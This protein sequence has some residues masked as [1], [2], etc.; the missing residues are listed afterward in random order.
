MTTL[1][2][3]L[4]SVHRAEAGEG[5]I[6]TGIAVLIMAVIGAAMYAAFSGTFT[7]ATTQVDEKVTQ[8]GNG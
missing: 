7:R 4:R 2:F 8:I 1:R 5:V 3:W 6:S